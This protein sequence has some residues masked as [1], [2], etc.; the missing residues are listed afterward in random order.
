MGSKELESLLTEREVTEIM[1]EMGWK[2]PERLLAEGAMTG[3]TLGI[4]QT[5]F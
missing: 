3:A 4:V 2:E 5:E 1:S